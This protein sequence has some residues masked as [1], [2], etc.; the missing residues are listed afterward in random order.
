MYHQYLNDTRKTGNQF[1]HLIPVSF[2][3]L[4]SNDT[5]EAILQ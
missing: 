4:K 5:L 3:P 2:N 1:L